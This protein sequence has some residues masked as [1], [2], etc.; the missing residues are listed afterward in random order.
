[1][2][3]LK[4][5]IKS[6]P[7]AVSLYRA[8]K[9]TVGS[10]RGRTATQSVFTQIY[11][12]NAWEGHASVSGRGS[13]DDQTEVLVK[14]LGG[15]LRD[16]K[17]TSMLDAPCGDFHWMKRVELA[18]IDYIGGDI[19]AELAAKNQM[20]YG[21]SGVRFQQ[22]NLCSDA[23]PT[24]DLVFCRDCIV[25]LSFADGLAALRNICASG[26]T[27]LLTTTFVARKRNDDIRTGDWRALNLEQKPYSLPKPLMTITEYCTEADGEFADKSLCLWRIADIAKAL[28][29]EVAATA[30]TD[31][32]ASRSHAV[33]R[34]D[35]VQRKS[36]GEHGA[37][38]GAQAQA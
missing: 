27:Y 13:D 36:V 8:V 9:R 16:L 37:R 14:A 2:K 26:S 29:V 21:A 17:I 19:V 11:R 12:E 10:L 30:S 22:M 4:N 33:R 38:E 23:L 31:A 28:G 7:G 18:G 15:V 20:K 1:M 3:Q 25:H 24:V 6:I 32:R 34:D 5:T 35:A